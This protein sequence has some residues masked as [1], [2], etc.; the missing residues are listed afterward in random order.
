MALLAKQVSAHTIWSQVDRLCIPDTK[1]K[2]K[3]RRTKR[4]AEAHERH[5][6]QL[7]D[8][9]NRLTL[10]SSNSLLSVNCLKLTL[11]PMKFPCSSSLLPL[12]LTLAPQLRKLSF[13]WHAPDVPLV[14]AIAEQLDP[15]RLI[16][17]RLKQGVPAFF[18]RLARRS[19]P[20]LV[21]VRGMIP[22]AVEAPN[23]RDVS[24][25]F[26]EPEEVAT[27]FNTYKKLQRLDLEPPVS[28]QGIPVE[29][30]R[31]GGL[32]AFET[33]ITGRPSLELFDSCYQHESPRRFSKTLRRLVRKLAWGT[34]DAVALFS[35]IEKRLLIPALQLSATTQ[36]EIVGILPPLYTALCDRKTTESIS[37]SAQ[38]HQYFKSLVSSTPLSLESIASTICTFYLHRNSHPYPT[39]LIRLTEDPDLYD[40][41]FALVCQFVPKMDEIDAA[42][43]IRVLSSLLTFVEAHKADPRAE[44]GLGIIRCHVPQLLVS[45]AR[46]ASIFEHYR[47]VLEPLHRL[48]IFGEGSVTDN[49]FVL[50]TAWRIE[51]AESAAR[52]LFFSSFRGSMQDCMRI[53]QIRRCFERCGTFNHLFRLRQAWW[54]VFAADETLVNQHSLQ[55]LVDRIWRAFVLH[56]Q[57]RLRVPVMNFL[58]VAI[59]ETILWE[60]PEWLADP[61][62]LQT[63]RGRLGDADITEAQRKR[64][65]RKARAGAPKLDRSL[66]EERQF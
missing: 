50:L 47:A 45:K 40:L 18:H 26:A 49:I 22:W 3:L 66:F 11:F 64:W 63:I 46:H 54:K 24:I 21:K 58:L 30:L 42:R 20:H 57:K 36:L 38:L 44:E 5:Y 17:I 9:L 29:I 56:C 10:G 34:I 4:L 43:G 39:W 35:V 65:N 28:V 32:S 13:N 51:T 19:W 59:E 2:I 62:T 14:A 53:Y 52:I 60:L 12:L 6:N 31:L 1:A 8:I 15:N 27:A 7:F 25:L 16:S 33:Q 61:S 41:I 48:G 23:L 37:T 55:V